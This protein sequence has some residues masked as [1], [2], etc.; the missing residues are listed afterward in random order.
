MQRVSEPGLA[1][2]L[3][4]RDRSQPKKRMLSGRYFTGQVTNV[5][6]NV[7]PMKVQVQAD[8][9]DAPSD[10]WFDLQHAHYYPRVGDQVDMVWR[11]EKTAQV[12]SAKVPTGRTVSRMIRLGAVNPTGWAIIGMDSIDTFVGDG[13]GIADPVD[14][15][16]FIIQAPGLYEVRGRSSAA[17]NRFAVAVYL[18]GNE[19]IRGHDVDTGGGGLNGGPVVGTIKCAPGD[20]VQLG[21]FAASIAGLEVGG[22]TWLEIEFKT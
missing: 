7:T 11:D 6:Y 13:L 22:N 15:Q 3:D 16:G 18:N 17:I 9:D 8:G 10:G 12:A 5:N 21:V 14:S 4:A 20:V 19:A 2:Y 1:G